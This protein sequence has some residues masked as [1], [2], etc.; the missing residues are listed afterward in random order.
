MNDYTAETGNS[1][2]LRRG[3]HQLLELY[4]GH[5]GQLFWAA[6]W[7]TVKHSPA[8]V[9]PIVI[10]NIINIVTDP[11]HHNLTQFW[12][13]L[14]V[15]SVFIAQNVL[16]AW[17]H[18]RASSGLTRGVEMELRGAMVHKLQRLS[19]QYHT[20]AQTGRLLSKIMR[21]VENVEQMM[22]SCFSSIV[23]LVTSVTVA[24]VVTALNDPRVLWLYAANPDKTEYDALAQ[25][26]HY[27]ENDAKTKLN[28][29]AQ[30]VT[31]IHCRVDH[32]WEDMRAVQ[33]RFGKTDGVV[34]LHAYQSFREGEVTP[35]QCHEIGVA[36][37]RRVWGKRFQ[38]L[39]ATHMNTDNLHNHFV[40][41][42]VSYVDGKKYEQRR[43]QYAEF[44]AA[45]DKLC[46][47]YGLSVVE[48]PKA[49]EP[50]RYARM[51]EAID[52]AC[53][54][55]STAEDFHRALYR[56]GYI[57]GSD[58]NRR[59]ATIR[60][61]DGGR[62][63]RLYRLGEEYDLAAIDDRLRGNYLL[64]G[65]R[66]YELKHPP[67][68][69]TPK[70]YRPQNTYAGKGVLQIFFEVFFGE[71]QMHRLY[72]YYCYQ[73]GILPKKQQPRIN[74]P[75]L[76]HIWKGTEKILAEH[77]FVHDHKFPSLQAI[78]DYR[79]GLSRQLETLAAQRAEIVKQ[80]R[81]KDAPPE[82]ADRRAVLTCKIAELR[83]EDKIAEGAIKRIQRTRE[84]NR[85][86]QEN[87][88]QHT[89]NKTHSRDSS[90][91]R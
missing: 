85:I 50:A 52:Q 90:R 58:P 22:Q 70:R 17:L 37:A 43:S 11:E 89:N 27:A 36:L 60:A 13:N 21:D 68:Q 35:E 86:E 30:L 31:G 10:A 16:T 91:R 9:T 38:V 19:I 28:E 87:R 74:R 59:Y 46:R 81:R 4:R 84:S 40:I 8:W 83:K 62:A 7:F 18:T 71:S 47:E 56:Q 41:N 49:K 34:A 29:S 82:L 12:L 15:G 25:T 57:F 20:Q 69:Y 2:N 33:E 26:L 66:M 88:N 77:A 24:V 32:A 42:S 39:V 51:R 14:I 73:L 72:L 3:A 79:K 48:Q 78:V 45:S 5:W 54:D 65:P 23:P 75:E 1:R 80:M 6:F 53:E 44:R 61:R 76:E 67:Q 55:A 64:Y 63:V